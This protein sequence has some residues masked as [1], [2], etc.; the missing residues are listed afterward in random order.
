MVK[1]KVVHS[2]KLKQT[3]RVLLLSYRYRLNSRDSRRKYGRQANVAHQLL[4]GSA[5]ATPA[6][7]ASHGGPQTN[8]LCLITSTRIINPSGSRNSKQFNF[9]HQVKHEIYI[10]THRKCKG[11]IEF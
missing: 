1:I 11:T 2:I 8:A 6:L 5:G 3:E 7:S 4:H 9:A 10:E